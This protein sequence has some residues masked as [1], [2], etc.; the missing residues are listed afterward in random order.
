MT[1][2]THDTQ[3]LFALILHDSSSS[4]STT[5][6]DSKR[7]SELEAELQYYKEMY[8]IEKE[9][10]ELNDIKL[11][12]FDLMNAQD[13]QRH[14]REMTDMRAKLRKLELSLNVSRFYAIKYCILLEPKNK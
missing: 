9:S 8:E 7:I 10:N 13:R 12:E 5:M 14:E 6:T 11:K 4:V 1:P 2:K 3:K